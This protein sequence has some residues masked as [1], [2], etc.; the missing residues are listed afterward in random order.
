MNSNKEAFTE[1]ELALLDL[2]Y[3][4]YANEDEGNVRTTSGWLTEEF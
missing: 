3:E 1:P 2:N 4:Y